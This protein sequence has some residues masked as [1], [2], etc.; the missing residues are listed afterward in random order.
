LVFTLVR[1]VSVLIEAQQEQGSSEVL[2]ERVAPHVARVTLNRPKVCNAV[3]SALARR[4]LQ[5]IAEVEHDPE[6]RVA[7]LTGAGDKAFCAGADLAEAVNA[8]KN[9]AEGPAGFAGFV[10]AVRSKPWIAAVRGYALG[11]GTELAL[12]CEM[13]IAGESSVFGLPEVKR[14]LVP[15]AG[16]VFRLARV[17]PKPVATEMLLSG[18]P[19]S[20]RRAYELGLLNEVVADEQVISRAME[21]AGRIAANAPLAVQECL[22]LMRMADDHSDEELANLTLRAVG[23]L[24]HTQDYQEGPRAFLEHR[25]PTWLGR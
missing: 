16:G 7:I 9:I 17:I 15:A 12:A 24:M 4:M 21:L 6:I 13:A 20:A 2:L 10:Y 1:E 22:K 18:D 5:V 23:K 14:S 8:Y 11:G 25:S 3:N 19:I